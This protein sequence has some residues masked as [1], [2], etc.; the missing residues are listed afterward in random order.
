MAYDPRLVANALLHKARERG[1]NL[2]HLKLQKL[3]FFVQ[4]WGLALHDN[5]VMTVLP[6]AWDY[7]PVFP[8][9]YHELKGYGSRPIVGYLQE[10]FTEKALV[11]N[12]NDKP[13]YELVDKVWERYGALSAGQLS[14]LSHAAGGPWDNARKSGTR[15]IPRTDIS[16]F[17]RNQLHA[18]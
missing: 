15:S 8:P 2:T 11:P 12:P 14:S 1:E 10:P 18:A 13:F 16:Q 7:G 4:A 6:E 3:L 17:Y 5:E 9:I